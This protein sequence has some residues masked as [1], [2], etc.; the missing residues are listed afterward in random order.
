MEVGLRGSKKQNKERKREAVG[1]KERRE[2]ECRGK[3]EEEEVGD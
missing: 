3:G 1:E 2:K